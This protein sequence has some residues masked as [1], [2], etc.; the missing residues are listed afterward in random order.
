MKTRELIEELSY[1]ITKPPDLNGVK[2][3]VLNQIGYEN[4]VHYASF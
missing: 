1:L 3:F 4:M 2:Y